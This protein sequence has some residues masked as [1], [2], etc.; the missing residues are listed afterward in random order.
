ML[1]DLLCKPE[2]YGGSAIHSAVVHGLLEVIV[3]IVES[4]SDVN[5]VGN[6]G[7]TAMHM[8]GLSEAG[9]HLVGE[10]AGMGAGLNAADAFG[11]LPLHRM[12]QNNLL[13]G[14]S[15]ALALGADPGA[16]LRTAAGADEEGL[17]PLH[18]CAREG[19]AQ[20][21]R[22]LMAHGADPMQRD[23]AGRLARDCA[24]A[25]SAEVLECLR[26]AARMLEPRA[27][28]D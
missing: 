25:R 11:Y 1:M 14:A 24:P 22:L 26:E 16:G 28:G 9:Q 13:Y 4:G 8:A 2:V 5:D 12:V 20:M 15:T 27:A 10:L 3:K 7:A 21:A 17:T 19:H 6:G 18:L 23:A